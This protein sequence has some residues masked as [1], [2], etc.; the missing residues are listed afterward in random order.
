MCFCVHVRVGTLGSDNCVD[1]WLD[2]FSA[3]CNLFVIA[4]SSVTMERARRAR[5]Q[6]P[7]LGVN[8]VADR[9]LTMVQQR[10]PDDSGG[11]F[12]WANEPITW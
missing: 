11:F 6:K 3:N 4:D 10:G 8:F 5:T 12:D 9:L 1:L 7:V 2:K